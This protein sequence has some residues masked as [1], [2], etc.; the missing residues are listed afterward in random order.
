M[1]D[2]KNSLQN[3]NYDEFTHRLAARTI[4]FRI[5]PDAQIH[6]PSSVPSRRGVVCESIV[7]TFLLFLTVLSFPIL[8]YA[9]N[10]W[11]IMLGLVL[12]VI[13]WFNYF[14]WFK[15]IKKYTIL[16]KSFYPLVFFSLL[17][18]YHY[19]GF[20]SPFSVCSFDLTILL[21]CWE[22]RNYYH[23]KW[24]YGVVANYSESFT[25]AITNNKIRVFSKF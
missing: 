3:L 1:Q 11:N 19:N 24:L 6:I 13:I 16:L 12:F 18:S 15:N 2:T 14:I 23:N 25:D 21:T 8:S 20:K 4:G 9:W 22:I 17:A 10:Q 5:N 7:F